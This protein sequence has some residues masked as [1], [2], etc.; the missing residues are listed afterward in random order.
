MPTSCAVN[1]CPA[2]AK[3]ALPLLAGG[4]VR[5]EWLTCQ[6]HA[7]AIRAGEEFSISGANDSTIFMGTDLPPKL[8]SVSA[9]GLGNVP[10]L[11]LNVEDR[12]GGKRQ[13]AIEVTR[14]QIDMLGDLLVKDVMFEATPVADA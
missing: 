9:V 11:L 5:L 4:E 6:L 3:T 14:D 2:E 1:G 12:D 10:T 7:D 13:I 8:E